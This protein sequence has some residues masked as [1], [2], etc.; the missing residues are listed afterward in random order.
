MGAQVLPRRFDSEANERDCCWNGMSQ[1]ASFPVVALGRRRRRRRLAGNASTHQINP[2][3][4]HY[5][6]GALNLNLRFY[7][8]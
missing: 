3:F 7:R 1:P 4:A 2:T 6:D 8:P 5:L